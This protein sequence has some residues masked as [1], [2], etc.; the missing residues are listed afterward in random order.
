MPSRKSFPDPPTKVRI[1]NQT[2][3]SGNDFLRLPIEPVE[4][5][6][7]QTTTFTNP[8]HHEKR[9]ERRRKLRVARLQKMAPTFEFFQE[10]WQELILRIEIKMLAKEFPNWIEINGQALLDVASGFVVS[11]LASPTTKVVG[12]K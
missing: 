9:E 6:N 12:L 2:P 3:I 11:G 4:Q 5:K 7:V 10:C 8:E 1:N